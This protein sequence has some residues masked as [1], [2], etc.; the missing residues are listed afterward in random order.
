M[1]RLTQIDDSYFSDLD[2][3]DDDDCNP[4]SNAQ[5]PLDMAG[6]PPMKQEPNDKFEMPVEISPP[7]AAP[8][9]NA[10]ESPKTGLINE[11]RR[12]NG[13]L[14][15]SLFALQQKYNDLTSSFT[16]Y[17]NSHT[18]GQDDSRDLRQV[19]EAT[20]RLRA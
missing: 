9:D 17:R 7:E 3:S 19:K 10:A 6:L 11:L 5:Q 14:T 12:D 16:S 2:M 1:P 15:A 8:V 20:Q 13:E 4:E 18:R